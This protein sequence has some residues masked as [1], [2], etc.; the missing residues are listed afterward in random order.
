VV[1]LFAVVAVV[2]AA[3]VGCGGDDGDASAGGGQGYDPEAS[4]TMTTASLTKAQFVKQLNKIC[5]EAWTTVTGNWDEYTST[6]DPKLSERK[7]FEEAVPL[8]LL[9]GLDFHIFDNVRGLGAPRGEE[10][11]IEEM[12]G[13]FQ[14]AVELGWKN[15]WRAHSI[16]EI[17]PHFEEYNAHARRQGLDDCLVDE[18]HLAPIES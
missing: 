10:A 6:Q 3:G 5:R 9:A 14:V 8:S 7:R 1:F 16:A 17:A 13:P 11:A 2:A 12:I 15:R 18:A 4:T